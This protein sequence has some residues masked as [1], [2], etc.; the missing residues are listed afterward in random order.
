M[1]VFTTWELSF[2]QLQSQSSE[3][4]FAAKLLTLFAFFDNRDISEQLFA[5][6]SADYDQFPESARLL[7]WLNVY[8]NA[9]G[10]WESDRFVETLISLRELSLLQGF[11]RE[12]DGFY[13]FSLHPL[14][15]D[16]ISLRTDLS[17]NQ[18]NILMASAIM[19]G[20]LLKDLT[21]SA[22]LS[23]VLH[24]TA[25]EES[26]EELLNSQAD[27]FS[28]KFF[29]DEYTNVQS[30]FASFLRQANVYNLATII[31]QQVAMQTE[32]IFGP[33]HPCVL[34]YKAD[35]ASIYWSQ[36]RWNEAEELQVPVIETIK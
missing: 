22:K 28:N 6:F 25:L 23:I 27:I 26:N 8:T 36:G 33:E 7:I 19:R 32:K 17:I 35:F 9:S 12:L 10:Q 5:E 13:H 20:M 4:D 16:W 24:V 11:A 18:E 3:N 21:L 31:Y 14:I 34:F 1:N 29:L 30:L 15:K 2:H